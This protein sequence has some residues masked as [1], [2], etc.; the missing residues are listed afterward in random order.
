[1]RIELLIT[2][3]LI[4]IN[5]CKARSSSAQ[6]QSDETKVSGSEVLLSF[7]DSRFLRDKLAQTAFNASNFQ[8]GLYYK[9]TGDGVVSAGFTS[10]RRD[11]EVAVEPLVLVREVGRAKAILDAANVPQI[12]MS[13]TEK[14]QTAQISCAS[15]ECKLWVAP[16][17]SDQGLAFK[18]KTNDVLCGFKV[19]VLGT[20]VAEIQRIAKENIKESNQKSFVSVE[21]GD[22]D[23]K[24]DKLASTSQKCPKQVLTGTCGEFRSGK[25]PSFQCFMNKNYKGFYQRILQDGD[26]FFH[27][28]H[29]GWQFARKGQDWDSFFLLL[30]SDLNQPTY[31]QRKNKIIDSLRRGETVQP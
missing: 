30:G 8:T 16:H 31:L 17:F 19:D 21:F 22:Y 25:T 24:N 1:M 18:P 11:R 10:M 26:L 29:G 7:D 27:Y 13:E 12:T 5:G 28:N 23:F 2:V 20:D 6:L 3:S 9:I 4:A 14:T 15:D